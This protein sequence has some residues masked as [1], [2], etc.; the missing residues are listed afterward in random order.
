MWSVRL[1][2]DDRTPMEFVGRLLEK[3]FDLDHDQAVKLMLRIHHKGIGG[4]GVYAEDAAKTKV[5]AVIAMARKYQ[6][7]LQC[8]M[9]RKPST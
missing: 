2:N 7:Q 5:A 1:I 8:T 6:H 4:C 3:L 9:E